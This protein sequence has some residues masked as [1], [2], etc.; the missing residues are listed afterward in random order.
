MSSDLAIRVR[1]LSKCYQVYEQP[2]HRLLQGIFRGR[3]QFFHEFW[4]LR[5]VSFEVNKGDTIGIIGRNGSGKSTL[6]QLICRTLAPTSG[7]V[8]SEGRIAALLELGAGFNPEFT[9]KENVYMNASVLG[10]SHAEISA[11]YQDIVAFADIGEFID[12]P[13]KTYSSGMFVR[14]AFAVVAHVDADIL[15]VDEALSVG[16]IAFQNKCMAH[17]RKMTKQGATILFVSHD[18]S[19]TQII[20]DRVV[21]LESGRVKQ[22]GD[23]VQVSRDYYVASLG[24]LMG[25]I[26]LADIVQQQE[27]GL[28]RYS[29]VKVIDWSAEKSPRF[30]VGDRVTIRFAL[31]A[32]ADLGPTVSAISVYRSDGDWLIGQTSR[33]NGAAP[34]PAANK[35]G[36]VKGEIVLDPLSLAPGEY[37]IALAAYSEDY[38]ICHALTDMLPGF[39]VYADYPTWGKFIHP[40][41]WHTLPSSIQ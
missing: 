9:G 16:D 32:L 38:H 18:L 41:E 1:N 19:T 21:W 40:I 15:V 7:S 29:E 8:E 17:L 28:A 37:R 24:K 31:T 22:I 2:Q 34:W 36:V 23:P 25:T 35:G 3:K 26:P 30:K 10:L 27:T 6:L 20:C 11:R 4:A 12:Q 39:T 33:D 13:V 5:D 14:L